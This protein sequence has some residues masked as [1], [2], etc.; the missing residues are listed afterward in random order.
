[1]RRQHDMGGETAGAI[2][3]SV[4]PVA[5]WEK[6]TWAM[7][8]VLGAEAHMLIRIDELRRAIEDL[9]P[10][11]Y[12]RAYFERWIMAVRDLLVEK[13]VLSRGEIDARVAL[14]RRQR[15]ERE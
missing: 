9:S 2:D 1:M 8:V 4:H 15:P 5:P 6:E 12:H 11:D 13:R 7:R 14:L 3:I 10:E